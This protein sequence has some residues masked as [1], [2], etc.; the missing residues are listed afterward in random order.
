[1]FEI[2]EVK[3]WRTGMKVTI[4]NCFDTNRDRVDL[5]Y[6]YFKEKSYEVTV[7]ESDFHHGKKEKK[8]ITRDD[9]LF[10]DTLPY[11]RNLSV[12]R[13]KSHDDFSKKAIQL[14]AD[15]QPDILYVMF[16]PNSLMKYASAYKAK[17][18]Q[19]KLIADIIDL[20]P[21]SM[22]VPGSLKKLFVFKMWANIRNKHL[23]KADLVLTE[24]HYYYD[25]LKKYIGQTKTGTLYLAQDSVPY[26]R[27]KPVQLSQESFDIC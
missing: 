3:D 23:A 1:M 4:V 6:D 27:E 14:A 10:I 20:W 18:P 9:F 5:I 19:V 17:N 12:G 2:Y 25:V 13:L 11:K 24:C 26:A 15:L 7:I 8:D 21:E 16:P 22:P